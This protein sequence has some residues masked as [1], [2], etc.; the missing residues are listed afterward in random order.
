MPSMKN[1]LGQVVVYEESAYGV[2][3]AGAGLRARLIS[4]NFTE[5]ENLQQ[6]PEIKSGR[7]PGQPYQDGATVNG[8]MTLLADPVDLGFWLKWGLGEPT[9]TGASAPYNHLYT[10]DAELISLTAELIETGIAKIWR[11]TGLKV[12]SFSIDIG[13]S[14]LLQITLNFMAKAVTQVALASRID[15]TPYQ[16]AGDRILVRGSSIGIE[17]ADPPTSIPHISRFQ[18]T[19][20]NQIEGYEAIPSEGYYELTEGVLQV[21]GSAS[22]LITD[23]DVFWGYHDNKDEVTILATLTSESGATVKAK[24]PEALLSMAIPSVQSQTGPT[25]GQLSYQGYYDD[26][27]DGSAVVFELDN[28]LASYATIPT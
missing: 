7:Q 19:V 9:T 17:D 8:S 10:A 5:N 12:Q 1:S 11:L 4:Y 14:G 2:V 20:D 28:A 25:P 15:A 23:T 22:V 24:V 6:S 21:S 18:M 3:P 16:A 13:T 26:D 27:A